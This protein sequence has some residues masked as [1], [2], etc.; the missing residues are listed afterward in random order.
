[1][2]GNISNLKKIINPRLQG[3]QGF[4]NTININ[5]HTKQNTPRHIIIKLL[6]TNN[7]EK[8]KKVARGKR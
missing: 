7:K 2:A 6:N 4:P 3:T 1:M 8:I 5:L